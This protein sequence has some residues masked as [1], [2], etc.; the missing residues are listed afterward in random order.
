MEK[1]NVEV[2]NENAEFSGKYTPLN[3]ALKGA[4][5]LFVFFWYSF[6]LFKEKVKKM[7]TMEIRIARFVFI[8]LH[9]YRKVL[10]WDS[11]KLS[12][13]LSFGAFF[14]SKQERI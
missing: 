8:A 13:C 9:G 14:Y 12:I 5:V 1:C 11:L 7:A 4:P 6:C 3:E 2:E 10:F